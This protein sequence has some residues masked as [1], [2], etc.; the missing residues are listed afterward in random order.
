MFL[1][2]SIFF[3]SLYLELQ[4]MSTN[5]TIAPKVSLSNLRNIY[6]NSLYEFC[7]IK[8]SLQDLLLCCSN[9]ERENKYYNKTLI[10][11]VL[12]IKFENSGFFLNFEI[13]LS[14]SKKCTIFLFD[15]R[16]RGL[17]QKQLYRK[18]SSIKSKLSLQSFWKTFYKLYNIRMRRRRKMRLDETYIGLPNFTTEIELVLSRI[19]K[20]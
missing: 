17:M 7:L 6:S 1:S 19:Q 8:Q 11:A 10:F 9:Q 20:L 16:I 18:V 3:L 14:Q 15:I 2:Q 4:S 13:L 5:V 12:C